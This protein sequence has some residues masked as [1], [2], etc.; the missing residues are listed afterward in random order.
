MSE[1]DRLRRT[2][3]D[4]CEELLASLQD[5]V[6]ALAVPDTGGQ[7]AAAVAAAFRAAHS[8]KGGAGAFGSGVLVEVAHLTE[9][10]LDVLRAGRMAP[11]DALVGTLLRAGDA[12]ADCVHADR[13][14][15]LLP[16]RPPVLADLHRLLGTET[17][18]S[19]APPL[20]ALPD[21]PVIRADTAP[22]PSAG[23][24]HPAPRVWT[25][26]F[27]P[28]AKALAAGHQPL[29]VLR[30]LKALGPLQTV[31]DSSH[32]PPLDALELTESYLRWTLSLTTDI[33]P[34]VVAEPFAFVAPLCPPQITANDGSRI[35]FDP[36]G[37]GS[38]L[39]TDS[40]ALVQEA[41][42]TPPPEPV[43]PEADLPLDPVRPWA[44]PQQAAASIRVDVERI[45][46]L[47]NMVGE[48]VITQAMLAQQA[49]G[50]AEDRFPMLFQG[51]EDLA[52]H[53]RELQESVMAIRAQP[54]KSAFA[55][56]PRLVR[57]TAQA[58]GKRARLTLIGE[59][60]E[61]DKSVVEGLSDPLMH[62]IRNAIDHGIETPEER[63]AAGKPED[64]TIT[65]LAEHR[66][67]RIVIQVSDDGA[68][69]NLAAIKRKAIEQGLLPK[70]ADP[71]EDELYDLM[72]HPGFSTVELISN[73]SGRGVG[74]DVVRANVN[75]LGGRILVRSYK[76]R[77]TAFALT[78]PL[79]LAVMDGMLL[80][81]GDETYV[82]PIANILESLQPAA[83]AIHHLVGRG[84]VLSVRGQYTPM[85]D[86]ARMFGHRSDPC[87]PTRALVVLCEAEDGGKVALVV[88]SLIGQQQVVIKSLERNYGHCEGISAATILGDGRVAL[89]LDVAGLRLLAARRHRREG[90]DPHG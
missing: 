77:G 78:L 40:L 49:Q 90:D 72:F 5:S 71:S 73:I 57:E 53:T 81:A 33:A 54:V 13:D 16:D 4:E 42:P 63:R 25:I 84:P 21:F 19:P 12:L 10:V 45:D 62:L 60:T 74:M 44:G 20:E 38:L 23:P 82:L 65:V 67:G 14:G 80:Q 48:L 51:L 87:D 55:R 41:D 1:L 18:A 83:D 79:T 39:T 66:S 70:G 30:A 8:I 11:S 52:S 75:A 43:S 34:E 3:F 69:I 36:L 64:G 26:D 88:D 76:G 15:V 61:V 89:I 56:L 35:G 46:R 85:V 37:V 32:I 68:G 2:F 31:C 9:T 7:H 29:L 28:N 22:T 58:L 17:S 47:V 27:A 6:T 59:E 50:L 86:L 24:T